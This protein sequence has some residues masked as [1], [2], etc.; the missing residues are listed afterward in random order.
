MI[1]RLARSLVGIGEGGRPSYVLLRL[2][3]VIGLGEE[4]AGGPVDLYEQ[5][6]RPLIPRSAPQRE[7]LRGLVHVGV[8]SS[9]RAITTPA[10]DVAVSAVSVSGP[11]PVEL[12]DYPSLYPR[13]SCGGGG[14][15]P[16]FYLIP[17]GELNLPENP[18][19]T[20][21]SAEPSQLSPSFVSGVMDYARL[22]LETW[23]LMGSSLL[24]ARAYE[25]IGRRPVVLLD[26]PTFIS[27]GRGVPGPME[28]RHRAVSRLESEGI[29][30]IGVV[31]R[32]E[33]SYI[34]SSSPRFVT[35]AER[36]GVRATDVADT[37]IL[38]Q[39]ASSGCSGVVP[40]RVYATPRVLVRADGLSKLVEY[41]VMVPSPLHRPGVRSR[42]YRL[43]YGEGT[44][45]LLREAGLE[46]IEA[47]LADT[48]LRQS[49][50]PVTIAAS[51]RRAKMITNA[52]KGLLAKSVLGMG[53]RV[54]Y[55]TEVEE[56]GGIQLA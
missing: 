48:V 47:F 41:V 19:I 10:A 49:L 52:L 11:G 12:C 40:G 1:D 21:V 44:L 16:F 25:S 13:L 28:V 6:S 55:E 30:V 38:Q 39:L 51:D 15:P 42:V 37:M 5:A 24:A 29:P 8:D 18:G 36:C 43:E 17:H 3:D 31:K 35:L 9:S 2:A 23:A 26:G 33:R 20:V 34:L 32:V 4:G 53:G 45:A 50:E 7:R 56:R 27:H 14:E 54:G 22:S 46:P